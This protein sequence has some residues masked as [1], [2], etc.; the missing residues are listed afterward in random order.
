MNRRTFLAFA[1]PSLILM[2]VLMVA[3]LA[4]TVYLSLNDFSYG[5]PLH[6]RG[7]G[8]YTEVLS[9]ATFW[10]ATAFTLV[11]TGGTTILKIIVGFALALALNHVIRARS[12]FLG[13]LLVPM[14]VPPVVG[15]LVFGWMFRD[16][17]GIGLFTY[18]LSETGVHVHWLS[19]P[20]PARFLLILQNTWQ[21]AAFGALILLAGLQGL[22]DEPLEAAMVDGAGWF[23]RVRHVIIPGLRGLFAFVALMSVM[24]AFRIFD[25][26]AVMTKGN[27]AGATTS[28]M[29]LNYQVAFQQQRLGLGSAI[30]VLT[31]G[32]IVLLMIPF[33]RQTRRQFRGE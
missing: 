21:D 27:P 14:I 19:E 33:I 8:N 13:L 10:H 15:A 20:W 12:F 29:Y 23:Q 25:N 17:I 9:Q 5:S 31:V 3:P 6:F 2:T 24:D 28:L 30:S 1:S 16:D 22:P 32:A 18:A 26:I 4:L 11:Y 7:L